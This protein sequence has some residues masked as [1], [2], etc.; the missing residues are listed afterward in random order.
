MQVSC[1][2]SSRKWSYFAENILIQ[3]TLPYLITLNLITNCEVL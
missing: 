1:F 3:L 2:Q